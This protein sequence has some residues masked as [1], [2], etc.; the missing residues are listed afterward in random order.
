MEMAVYEK[1]TRV[2][3]KQEFDFVQEIGWSNGILY[4]KNADIH[5]VLQTLDRLVW[6]DIYKKW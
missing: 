4:F 3:E 5:E 1:S 2:T 6:C